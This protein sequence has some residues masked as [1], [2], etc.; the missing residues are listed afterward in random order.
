MEFCPLYTLNNF[1]NGEIDVIPVLSENL[2]NGNYLI[3]GIDRLSF[4]YLGFSC[5]RLP[6]NNKE[7]R[8]AISRIIDKDELIKLFYQ[9]HTIPK[10]TNNY[11][12]PQLPG[13]LPKNNEKNLDLAKVKKILERANFKNS[14]VNLFLDVKEKVLGRK[15]YH[16]LKS[17]LDFLNL[18]L[19]LKFYKSK[20]EILRTKEP[21]LIIVHY[22][23]DFPEPENIIV[24][25]FSSQSNFNFFEFSNFE[26]DNLAKKAETEKS[27][28]KRIEIFNQIE[29]ILENE[30]PAIPLYYVQQRVAFQNYVKGIEVSPLG[31]GTLNAWK[32][33]LDK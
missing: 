10:L 22:S 8:D 5:Q 11:I 33:W 28:T 7:V 14:T 13:F 30:V 27:W 21:Y 24:P 32:I 31:F 3:T 1:L 9:V 6:F 4:T 16:E 26:I 20:K 15:I 23:M 25:L 29:K 17:Q 12:P 19:K 18:K 2:L